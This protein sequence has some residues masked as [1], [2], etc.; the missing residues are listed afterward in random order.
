MTIHRITHLLTQLTTDQAHFPPTELY[1]EGWM[2][3]LVVDW[4][5]HNKVDHPLN[6]HDNANWYSEALLP[7]AFLPRHRGDKLSESRTHADGVIGH[8]DIGNKGKA[9]FE[10]HSNAT[11]FIVLEAKMS[12][13]LSSGVSN[14]PYFDQAARNVGCIAETLSR[15]NRKANQLDQ[16]GFYVLA[17]Q[18]HI[19]NGKF[20]ELIKHESIKAKMTRRVSGF[21]GAKEAW[22][23]TWFKPLIEVIDIQAISW[24]S[25]VDFV[26]GLDEITGAQLH[27]FYQHCLMFN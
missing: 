2:L 11:Q 20:A 25:L 26:T 9:D 27:E 22:H 8:F 12:S 6:F 13:G 17:P 4:F 10:L 16:I 15:A 14:A 3:R 5:Q 19:D 23:E 1:N 18:E 21:E 7:S 24:E